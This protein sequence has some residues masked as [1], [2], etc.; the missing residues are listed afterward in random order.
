MNGS[1]QTKED[2]QSDISWTTE[3]KVP[4][5]T[6]K[7][8]DSVLHRHICGKNNHFRQAGKRNVYKICENNLSN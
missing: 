3:I 8:G 2:M 7:S 4:T 5:I 6:C 1:M